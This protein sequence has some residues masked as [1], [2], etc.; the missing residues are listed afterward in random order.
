[1]LKVICNQP[2]IGTRIVLSEE[3]HEKVLDFCKITTFPNEFFIDKI[4]KDKTS[5]QTYYLCKSS[6]NGKSSKIILTQSTI[7]YIFG[8]EVTDLNTGL[9]FNEYLPDENSQVLV[10][11]LR[12]PS[13]VI[14]GI[15]Q[16][17]INLVDINLKSV[18]CIDFKINYI[19]GAGFASVNYYSS[20]HR[21]YSWKLLLHEDI[22]YMSDYEKMFRDTLIHKSFVLKSCDI[23]A[24]YLD[25]KGAIIHAQLLR[26]RAVLHDNSKINDDDE[27]NAL[28]KIINDKSSLV[29]A[30]IQ[31]SPIKQ[32]AIKLHWK[33][34]RHHPEFH[35]SIE[36]MTRLDLMEMCCDWHARS[37]QYGTDFLN[38]VE[39][40]QKDRFHFPDW[41]YAEVI[42]YCKILANTI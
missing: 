10:T 15:F 16:I 24:N 22:S 23:L 5:K 12:Y 27:L 13:E 21:R 17:D 6:K 34:N 3:W 33:H 32:E 37:S 9:C 8:Q 38:F 36:D 20:E 18:I 42:Y 1:M 7:N 29:D 35:S 19:N 14:P 25:E 4:I 41:M 11:N 26:E 40:R 2:Q 30:S 31:L 28:S 39:T